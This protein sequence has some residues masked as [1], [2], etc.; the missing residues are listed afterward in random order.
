MSEHLVR[1][2]LAER[3]RLKDRKDDADRFGRIETSIAVIQTKFDALANVALTDANLTVAKK[4]LR[5]EMNDAVENIRRDLKDERERWLSDMR[6]A[7]HEGQEETR[8]AIAEQ[9]KRWIN[10]ALM[11]AAVVMSVLIGGVEAGM[12]ALTTSGFVGFG[13]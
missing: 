11:V 2:V 3:E 12:K 10:R 6:A 8:K 5:K 9:N 4:E 1:D 13:Q 7:V